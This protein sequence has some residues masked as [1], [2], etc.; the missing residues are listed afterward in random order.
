M[1]VCER[2]QETLGQFSG[3]QRDYLDFRL[4]M[5]TELPSGSKTTAIKQMGVSVGSTRNLVLEAFNSA[6]AASKF[7]TSNATLPPSAD[8]CQSE[9]KLVM[10]KVP[11]PISY[12][13]QPWFSSPKMVL[14]FSP[15]FPE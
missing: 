14:C 7:S 12:S 8:G 15:S 10:A 6:I 3:A 1:C 9:A 13:I 2:L 4:W 11:G 5:Q